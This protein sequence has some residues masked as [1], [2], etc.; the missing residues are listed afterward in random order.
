MEDEKVYIAAG[1]YNEALFYAKE[2]RIAKGN[3]RFVSSEQDFYGIEGKGKTLLVTQG[4]PRRER[5]E[6]ILYTARERRFK[7]RFI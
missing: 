4:A 1:E 3:L 2:L 6:A 7:I 5:Y